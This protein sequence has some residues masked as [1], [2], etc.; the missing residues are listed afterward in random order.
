[1]SSP[2]RLILVTGHTFGLRAFEG[3]FAAP[4]YLEGR[5]S[6]EMMVGLDTGKAG[7][8]VGFLSSTGLAAEQG[9]RHVYTADGRLTALAGTI[10]E[11]R[12]H[13]LL[14]IGWSRLVA[15]E[16]L[17][18]PAEFAEPGEKAAG[19]FGC[20][21]MHPTKL[22]T[23]RGQAP[24][25]WTII[26]GLRETAL[27]VFF[28]EAAADTGSL[29]AQYD[30][31]VHP[32]ETAASLFYRVAGTHFTAGFELA[33]RLADRSVRALPQDGGIATV[34][35]KRRPADGEISS[36]MA[37]DEIDALVRALLGPYP[38]AFVSIGGQ[39]YPVRSAEYV[40]PPTTRAAPVAPGDPGDP[41]GAAISAQVEVD[42]VYLP[43]RDGVV[44]L[45]RA[46][47]KSAH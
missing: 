17:A 12:P 3:I 41:A 16:V 37:F 34:W 35:P 6:V 5:L 31:P 29:I 18:I 44:R 4:A 23:G 20:I 46:D 32:R 10:R 38:R 36:S 19:A 45:L 43:C 25:P 21:G 28:L 8:T 14:V 33:G 30:L 13:Y 7:G 24:I 47:G 26:K 1:M 11:C 9:V 42:C 27:S 39:Q 22:P 15:P 2:T 40:G